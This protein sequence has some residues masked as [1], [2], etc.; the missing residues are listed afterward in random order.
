MSENTGRNRIGSTYLNSMF[1]DEVSV[2]VFLS[3]SSLSLLICGME[4]GR[5]SCD[6]VPRSIISAALMAA[7]SKWW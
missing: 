3:L 5:I 2:A 1:T 4:L 6:E 7:V